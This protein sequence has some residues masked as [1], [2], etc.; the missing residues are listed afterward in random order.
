ML[1]LAFIDTWGVLMGPKAAEKEEASGGWNTIYNCDSHAELPL[2]V[3]VNVYRLDHL[4]CYMRA[5]VSTSAKGEKMGEKTRTPDH[6][7]FAVESLV[8]AHEDV[9]VDVGLSKDRMCAF[10]STR[11]GMGENVR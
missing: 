6:E 2:H 8:V 10:C 11:L 5:T 7:V 3:G 1:S 9:E 4:R